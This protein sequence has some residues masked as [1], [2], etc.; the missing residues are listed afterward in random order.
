M[1]DVINL[2]IHQLQELVVEALEDIKAEDIRIIDMKD[3][4][5]FTD[6]MIIA[7]GNSNRQVKALANNVVVKAKAKGAQVLGME[8]EVDAEWVLIDL[9][10]IVVHIMQPRIRDF[11]NLE[12]LWSVEGQQAAQAPDAE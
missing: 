9:G 5:A 6:V 2:E 3:M 8:G 11:Y 4:A 10:D 1:S 12:K 7:S